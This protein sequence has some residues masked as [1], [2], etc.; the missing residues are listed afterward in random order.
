MS[1]QSLESMWFSRPKVPAEHTQQ[2]NESD[3]KCTRPFLFREGAGTQA[4][5]YLELVRAFQC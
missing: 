2:V 1:Q 4:I 3:A 5:G